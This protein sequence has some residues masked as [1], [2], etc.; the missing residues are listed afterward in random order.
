MTIRPII[1]NTKSA[2][3]DPSEIIKY[4]VMLF[5]SSFFTVLLILDDANASLISTRLITTVAV[6]DSETFPL[7]F[8]STTSLCMALSVSVNGRSVLISPEKANLNNPIETTCSA[9][10]WSDCF[11]LVTL[12]AINPCNHGSEI[13]QII[14]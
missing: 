14:R 9:Y 1:L 7:S 4:K 10:E 8:T 13:K 5:S 11:F 3:T 2:E 12:T 6:A